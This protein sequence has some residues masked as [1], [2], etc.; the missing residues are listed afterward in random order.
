MKYLLLTVLLITTY[1]AVAQP[2]HMELEPYG[3]DA[4][5]IAVPA[6]PNEKL[7]DLSESWAAQYRRRKQ[8]IDV[9]NVTET[10]MVITAFKKNAFYYSNKGETFYHKIRY[11]MMVEFAQSTYTVTFKVLDIYLDDDV[12]LEYKV[13]DYFTSEG[14][15]KD[16]YNTLETSLEDTVNDIVNSHY[17][18]IINYR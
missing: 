7:I 3:F 13:P 6:T 15:L 2:P 17:N 5:S 11:E 14:V 1:A 18:F 8:G 10:S 12:L 9:T 4:V 16:G